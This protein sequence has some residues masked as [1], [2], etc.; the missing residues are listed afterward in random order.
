MNNKYSFT[1]ITMTDDSNVKGGLPFGQSLAQKVSIDTDVFSNNLNLFLVSFNQVLEKQ[2]RSIGNGFSIDEV[3][4]NLA[5][6]VSGGIEL[7][8]KADIG[9]QSAIKVKLKREKSNES[10]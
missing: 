2:P 8:G 9:V 5:V 6:N 1:I 3:E 4:L 7:I 10:E